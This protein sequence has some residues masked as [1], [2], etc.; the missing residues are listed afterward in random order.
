MK[1]ITHFAVGVA[2]ASC[3]PEAVQAGMDG[4][5]LCFILGGT[6]GLLPDTLDF[7]FYKFFYRRD[8]EI[9][10]D[11]NDPDPAMIA[12]AVAH[13]VAWCVRRGK[14]V[15]VKLN[16]AR[17]GTGTWLRYVVRFEPQNGQVVVACGPVVTTSRH[18][19]AGIDS[20]RV[21]E[22]SAPLAHPVVLD[23]ES[24]TTI[25]IFDGPTFRMVPV[26]GRV[27][28][29]FIPWHREWSH[30]LVLGLG[31]GLAGMLA[32]GWAAGLIIA[33]AHASHV[34]VDQ[35]GFLGGNLLFPLTR[36]RSMGLQRFRSGEAFWN[37]AF[38]WAAL[39]VVFWNLYRSAPVAHLLN[40]AQVGLFGG[41]LPLGA[42]ALL[43]R[44]VKDEDPSA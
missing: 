20:S 25:D 39:L 22:A 41:L 4:N 19:V 43:R 35:L 18:T 29:E 16:S 11:P 42:L 10:P 14:P 21:R 37:F 34:L 36:A 2:V 15:R 8:M 9:M 3:F 7:K 6:S 24:T 27:R 13:A 17:L 44:L 12:Q 28:L 33:V 31:L 38:V 26:D 1:G 40:V 23:Y 30:S 5:P 32:W